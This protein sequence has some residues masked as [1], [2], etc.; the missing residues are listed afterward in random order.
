[1]EKYLVGN[2]VRLRINEVV[3]IV[4]VAEDYLEVENKNGEVFL[5]RHSDVIPINLSIEILDKIGFVQTLCKKELLHYTYIYEMVKGIDRY[6]LRG[7]V[8]NH[9][10]MWNMNNINFHSLNKLQSYFDCILE[11][12][13]SIDWNTL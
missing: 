5:L 1:M 4:T 6:Y 13:L 2:Y 3:K 8:F 12:P 9:R 7:F 11:K 10:S